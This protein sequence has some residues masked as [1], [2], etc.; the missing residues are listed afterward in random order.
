MLILSP[1]ELEEL[2]EY[3]RPADQIKWLRSKGIPFFLGAKG[4]PKVLR[5]SLID[6]RTEPKLGEV[7]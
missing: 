2:T 1:Q 6:R 4:N 5:D 7:T 3:K